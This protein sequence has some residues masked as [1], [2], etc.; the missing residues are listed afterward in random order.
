VVRETFEWVGNSQ[1]VVLTLVDELAGAFTP[2]RVR[3]LIR[4]RAQARQEADHLPHG[5]AC[6]RVGVDVLCKG[7]EF[8]L[9]AF[10]LSSMV[11]RSRKAAA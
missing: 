8:N 10:Q 7:A 9:P 11:I 3:S 6:R 5:A 1:V 2:A 4:L